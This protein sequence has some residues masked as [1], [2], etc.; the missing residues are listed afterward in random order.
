[1]RHPLHAAVTGNIIFC[2]TQYVHVQLPLVVK[3]WPSILLSALM[4]D[5]PPPS[6]SLVSPPEEI[7]LTRKRYRH[8]PILYK[9]SFR[10]RVHCWH[11]IGTTANRRLHSSLLRLPESLHFSPFSRRRWHH[12]FRPSSSCFSSSLVPSLKT[13]RPVTL[14]SGERKIESASLLSKFSMYSTSPALDT[15]VNECWGRAV[16]GKTSD[17]TTLLQK[18]RC[19]MARVVPRNT[20]GGA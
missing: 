17:I 14:P 2:T 16:V 18:I 10:A 15:F 13:S 9:K 19:F 4:L 3:A 12:H 20:V 1:M 11:Q 5:P 7:M 6:S 8:S